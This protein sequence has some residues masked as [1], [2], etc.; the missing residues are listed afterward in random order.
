M[1]PETCQISCS[2]R[3]HVFSSRERNF[4]PTCVR[5]WPELSRVKECLSGQYKERSNDILRH[6]SH[7]RTVH[8]PR[9][10][11]RV[12]TSQPHAFAFDLMQLRNVESGVRVRRTWRGK[13]GR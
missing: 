5:T 8:R 11:S 9:M 13:G 2:S 6:R 10:P 12:G 1:Q 4:G 3:S 7:T